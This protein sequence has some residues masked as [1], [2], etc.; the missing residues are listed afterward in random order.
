MAQLQDLTLVPFVATEEAR[1]IPNFE[2]LA[3][4]HPV[5]L[6]IFNERKAKYF[7][8]N[9]C[10]FNS[11]MAMAS[12]HRKDVSLALNNVSPY[13][14]QGH[15]RH[16]VGSTVPLPHKAP[17]FLQTYFF[18]PVEASDCLFASIRTPQSLA[19]QLF[20]Q[21]L[22]LEYHNI[23]LDVNKSY[24]NT[25][26][27]VRMEMECMPVLPRDLYISINANQQPQGLHSGQFNLPTTSEMSILMP[28][29]LDGATKQEIIC[30]YCE[31]PVYVTL[32]SWI[33]YIDLTT[34]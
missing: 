24:I 1:S 32:A 18:D 14:I 20:H 10:K 28:N 25:F 2:F 30:S 9:V 21:E 12:M 34:L 22:F 7:C 13:K 8:K 11:G 23:L 4:L 5:Y 33:T 29:D 6:Y 17:K 19:N 16:Y 27:S 3:D 31:Q 26:L 15:L